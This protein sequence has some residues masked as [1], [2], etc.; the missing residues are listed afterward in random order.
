MQN[1]Y[2]NATAAP[3]AMA[4]KLGVIKD[5]AAFLSSL[6][7]EE[8]LLPFLLFDEPLLPLLFEDPLLPLF[9]DPLELFPVEE[10]LLVESSP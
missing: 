3:N 9:D 7:V 8:S 5:P 6:L 4:S 10:L 1:I 2:R